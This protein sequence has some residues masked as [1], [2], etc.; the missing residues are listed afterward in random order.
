MSRIVTQRGGWE[1]ERKSEKSLLRGRNPFFGV[2][3]GIE[4]DP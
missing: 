3:T 4:A 1:L 2:E